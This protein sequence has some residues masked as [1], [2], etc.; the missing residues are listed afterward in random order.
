MKQ[1]LQKLANNSPHKL[2]CALM[3]DNVC[4]LYDSKSCEMMIVDMGDEITESTTLASQAFV[5]MLVGINQ[6][7]KI[8][9]NS[10]T[11]EQKSNLVKLCLMK[12][13]ESGVKVVSLTF[14]GHATKPLLLWS[15][16]V[17]SALYVCYQRAHNATPSAQCVAKGNHSQARPSAGFVAGDKSADKFACEC[18]G[19]RGSRLGAALAVWRRA[20]EPRRTNPF[21][22]DHRKFWQEFI[23]LFK[24]KTC[25]W[26]VK[27]KGYHSKQL[28]Q[29]VYERLVQKCKEIFPQVNKEFVIKKL[30]SL[31]A[32]LRKVE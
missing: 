16:A 8:P 22:Y 21:E 23:L 1:A 2:I 28:K 24:E 4:G 3:F 6:R 7:S 11:G 10:L 32:S 5:F 13:H 31:R 12:C 17:L 15:R 25:L 19:V 14:D 9:S 27:S 29:V 18:I 20:P 26:E 30:S